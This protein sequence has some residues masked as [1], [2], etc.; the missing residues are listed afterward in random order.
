MC[1]FI[2]LDIHIYFI[3]CSTT[4]TKFLSGGFVYIT[5]QYISNTFKFLSHSFWVPYFLILSVHRYEN[6]VH[7]QVCEIQIY[8]HSKA[9]L[10]SSEFVLSDIMKLL[11]K[12]ENSFLPLLCFENN[13][14]V[15]KKKKKIRQTPW[16]CR[17]L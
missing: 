13:N 14:G 10:I 4:D 9:T 1:V 8:S 16:Y 7:G 2:Y 15:K 12:T 5:L 17:L 3:F 6:R 11:S